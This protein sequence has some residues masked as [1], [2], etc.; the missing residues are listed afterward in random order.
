ML[1]LQFFRSLAF[2][3]SRFLAPSLSFSLSLYLHPLPHDTPG[4]GR[5]RD[6]EVE[7]G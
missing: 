6:A 3:L 1:R 5:R 7:D 2:S 4:E